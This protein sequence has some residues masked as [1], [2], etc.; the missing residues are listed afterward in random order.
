MDISEGDIR[1][2]LDRVG[3]SITYGKYVTDDDGNIVDLEFVYVNSEFE[4]MTGFT[5]EELRGKHLRS[6]FESSS[7][8]IQVI[9]KGAAVARDKDLIFERYSPSTSRWYSFRFHSPSPDYCA[10]Y[11]LDV[12]E[13]RE[14]DERGRMGEV[15]LYSLFNAIPLPI[16]FKTLSGKFLYCNDAFADF[17]S[18]TKEEVIGQGVDYVL[19]S[20][21]AQQISE[22][23]RILVESGGNQEFDMDIVTH[24]ERRNIRVFRALVHDEKGLISGIV[25]VI[26]NITESRKNEEDIRKFLQVVE[27]SPMPII[28]T[29]RNGNI[30]YV[31]SAFSTITG[32]SF[33]EV[34]GKN[35]RILKSGLN[36][37][38]VYRE[39]WNAISAGK[40]WHGEFHNRKKNNALYWEYAHISALK[41]EKDE[42]T[43]Y[44]AIKEDITLR[45]AMED[46]LRQSRTTVRELLD[47]ISGPAI[48]FRSEGQVIAMN[49]SAR[50]IFGLKNRDGELR[51]IYSILPREEVGFYKTNF[52]TV[53]ATGS[54]V[55]VERTI[56]ETTYDV[57]ICPIIDDNGDILRIAVYA[58]DISILKKTEE[59]LRSAAAASEEANRAKSRFVAVMS[60]EIRTPLNAIMGLTDLVLAQMSKENDINENVWM[61]RRSAEHLH[62]IVD[63][64]LDFSRIEAGKVDLEKREFSMSGLISNMGKL[65]S[66]SAGKKRVEVRFSSAED[67]PPVL[68]GDDHRLSQI[69]INLIGNALKFTESGYVEIHGERM[70]ISDPGQRTWVRISVKDTGIGIPSD[71]TAAIFESFTQAEV[72]TSRTYGGSGLGLTISKQ[73]TELMGGSIRVESEEGKG[74]VFI[75]EIPFKTGV[76]SEKRNGIRHE[77][78]RILLAEDNEIN[79]KLTRMVLSRAGHTVESAFD[80]VDAISKL[81]TGKYDLVLMDVEMP[82]VDGFEATRRIRAGEAGESAKHVPII[83]ITAHDIP[84]M[85]ELCGMSGMNG[86]LTKPFT[87]DSLEENISRILFSR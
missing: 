32:Y 38:K 21:N 36:D 29:D 82:V 74:S 17:Y 86:Y 65:F 15:M 81:S 1:K 71:R 4:K 33:G 19:P 41:N 54:V 55:R 46:E 39:L 14:S 31:N 27:Q 40:E 83:A 79:V 43:N 52:S 73:L 78:L 10:A 18:T 42:I 63:N 85:R 48:L 12:T 22:Y 75:I 72:K 62:A 77:P 35:P 16:F 61:I 23:D 3:E 9:I 49:R 50:S 44:I 70:A 5:R 67:I 11:I 57:T 26:F 30:E 45:K 34:M 7:D 37:E 80:G 68:I 87:V 69:L 13:K 56:Q 20:D 6:L 66:A 25:G 64:I 53:I 60:H 58:H 51:D 47:A 8:L 59:M 24:G 84:E 76:I 2:I 28:I